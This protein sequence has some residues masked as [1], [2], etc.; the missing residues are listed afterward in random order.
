MKKKFLVCLA[1]LYLVSSSVFAAGFEVSP[2]ATG[3]QATGCKLY[4]GGANPVSTVA[5]GAPGTL[6]CVWAGIPIA[7]GESFAATAFNDA[8]ESGAS[9]AVVIP[10]PPLAPATMSATVVGGAVS[11]AW[12]ASATAV[13]YTVERSVGVGSTAFALVASP[14]TTAYTDTAVT[15]GQTYNYIVKAVNNL[16]FVSPG[17]SSSVLVPVL[18]PT[19]PTGLRVTAG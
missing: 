1:A 11:V 17:S 16:K 7:P 15:P 13:S 19:A 9:N 14:T 18:I 5:T 8:G 6:T 12:A 2:S 4:K 10:N 3:P